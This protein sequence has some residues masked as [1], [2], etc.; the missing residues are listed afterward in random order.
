MDI[1]FENINLFSFLVIFIFTIKNQIKRP[2]EALIQ[3]LKQ[4]NA[5]LDEFNIQVKLKN[6]ELENLNTVLKQKEDL[7]HAFF[8]FMPHPIV[9][10]NSENNRI[11]FVNKRFLDIMEINEPRKIINKKIKEYMKF[12]IDLNESDFNCILYAG[13]KRKY[14]KTKF[15]TNYSFDYKKLILIE[16]NTE[17]VKIR[18]MKNEVEKRKHNEYVRT[19][20]LSSISH[21]LKTPVNVIYSGLQ[22]EQIFIEKGDVEAL[23]KYN[24]ICRQNCILLMAFANNLID[25]SKIMSDYIAA[26]LKKVNLVEVVE[27]HV[28]SFV[29]YAKWNGIELI[30]DTNTEE[31]MIEID[32]E[33]MRRIILNLISNGVKYTPENGKIFVVIEEKDESVIINVKDTGCGVK[34]EIKDL[35][36]NRYISSNESVADSKSGTGL[37]LFVVKRLVELQHGHIYL[38]DSV[39]MGTS[40]IIEFKRGKVYA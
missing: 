29:D 3:V 22:L 37:G 12:M 7:N 34:K 40:I 6:E 4:E 18:E 39:T 27:E 20:F 35:I 31:C 36:F 17:K 14:L 21:D 9:M 23:R 28:M 2:Y 15:L 13:E 8:R 24:A 16:D 5:E 19:Q 26:N 33:F 10:L 11:I 30:F 25:N 38:D 1:L 32:T